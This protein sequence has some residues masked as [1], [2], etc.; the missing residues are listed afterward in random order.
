M[1]GIG[2]IFTKVGKAVKSL[3]KPVLVGA[4]AMFVGGLALGA[5]PAT[6]AFADKLPGWGEGGLF[7]KAAASMGLGG[8]A[9]EGTALHTAVNQSS[10][11]AL[12]SAGATAGEGALATTAQQA[13]LPT[14]NGLADS[15]VQKAAASPTDVLGSQM[16][17]T[18]KLMTLKLG[19]DFLGGVMAPTPDDM[20]RAQKQFR[21]SFYGVGRNG[22]GGGTA[23]A[24]APAPTDLLAPGSVGSHKP[25]ISGD[26]LLD[27]SFLLSPANP[28][29]RFG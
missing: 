5:F 26:D 2:K 27:P 8:Y 9:A 25:L 29:G 16:E 1:R 24:N 11:A 7:T 23:P 18:N 6:S 12:A 15:V 13:S 20:A 22:K 14:T 3:A 28:L 19:M 10:A 17:R 21:G 4:A